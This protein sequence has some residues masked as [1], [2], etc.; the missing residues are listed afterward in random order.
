M[1]LNFLAL[2]SMEFLTPRAFFIAAACLCCL[3]FGACHK[4]VVKPDSTVPVFYSD[5]RSV[6]LLPTQAMSGSID[7]AQRLEGHFAKPD[8]DTSSFSGDTWVR[9]NDSI[10]SI[11]LFGGFGTTIA[12]LTYTKD[13]VS[14]SSSFIDGE[15]M[16]AEYVLADFQV[17][18]YPFDALKNNFEK[19]GFEFREK[20]EGADFERTLLEDG[21][22]ILLVKKSG[23]EIELVNEL[24]KYRYHITLSEN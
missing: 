7:M 19:A 20:V 18:F 15:K 16:K 14:L 23:S 13:S 8:G 3:F 2:L 17:C 1:N 24:R 6:Q 5:G 10:L 9:A 4:A 21:N 11:H 12:E 22:T